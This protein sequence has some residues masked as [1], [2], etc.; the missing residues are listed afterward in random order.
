M[1]DIGILGGT[2]D[3][4]HSGHLRLASLF[5]EALKLD[6]V[7]LMPACVPP[8]KA[9][10]GTSSADRL[11]MCRLAAEETDFLEVCDIELRRGGK[12]YTVDTMRHLT[13]QYPND[14]FFFL[15]GSD[16]FLCF[17]R[18]KNYEEIF[19][20]CTLCTVSREE[21]H[22][23]QELSDF[24]KKLFGEEFE[25]VKILPAEPVE[26]SS[27]EVRAALAEGKDIADLVPEK[28]MRYISERG[29][30]R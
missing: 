18:W 10:K 6:R 22:S 16:M 9:D 29:L 13:N 8:H 14:K 26:I 30:Y 27:T 19:S 28:V 5:K 3:P 24:A 25:K 20:L 17:D 1:A 11:E 21:E 23:S 15:M 4:P 12:S 7:L 2:F